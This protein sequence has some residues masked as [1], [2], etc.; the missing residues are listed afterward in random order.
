MLEI[1]EAL[2]HSISESHLIIGFF[3]ILNNKIHF[4]LKDKIVKLALLITFICLSISLDIFHQFREKQLQL[5][6]MQNRRVR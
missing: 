1:K 5:A 6:Q 3:D 2:F 4:V